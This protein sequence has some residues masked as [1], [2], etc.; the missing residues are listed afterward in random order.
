MPDTGYLIA[1]VAVCA[2]IT[3]SLRALPFALLAPLRTSATV[4]Y[5]SRHMPV[6]VM[7]VLAAYTLRDS[8]PAQWTVTGPALAVTV[9]VHLW[10]RNAV[11]S[12]LTGT[13]LH[14]VLTML[15]VHG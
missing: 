9:A 1:A 15:F 7:V 4:A 3:W 6:G 11:L 14:V 13:A 2:A 10:R 5:L 8:T 12:I